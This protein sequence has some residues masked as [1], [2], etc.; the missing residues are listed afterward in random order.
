MLQG[1]LIDK[2]EDI[3]GKLLKGKISVRVP[4][5]VRH[6]VERITETTGVTM[7][8]VVREVLEE[9]FLPQIND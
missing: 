8:Q 3:K 9:K 7:S 1:F 4:G 5:S 2:M 6:E